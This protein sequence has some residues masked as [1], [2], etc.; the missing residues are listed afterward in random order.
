VDA[1]NWGVDPAAVSGRFQ[2]AAR[3]SADGRVLLFTSGGQ[4]TSYDN[5]GFDEIYRYDGDSGTV[6]CVSCG[7]PGST[8]VSD[9]SFG[10]ESANGQADIQGAMPFRRNVL[11]RDGSRVF[12]Q[13]RDALVPQDTN[14]RVDVYEWENGTVSLISSGQSSSDAL[15]GDASE[16]GSS[17]FFTTRDRL[18]AEDIDANAD[19]YVARVEGGHLSPVPAL[20]CVRDECQG[21]LSVPAALQPPTTDTYFGPGNVE[22]PRRRASPRLMVTPIKKSALARFQRTGRLPLR[23]TATSA[24]MITVTARTNVRNRL[25]VVGRATKRLQ[26]PG[27]TQMTLR[28]SAVGRRVLNSRSRAVVRVTVSMPGASSKTA[29]LVLRT[30]RR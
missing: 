17:V 21:G 4:L 3:V 22:S 9:A 20:A 2:R 6:T 10:S 13:T 12:F 18:V 15:F 27:S 1:A 25:R 5:L 8:P 23:V 16:D 24:G 29:R 19:L 28:L 26:R 11:S 30:G 7:A 14:E